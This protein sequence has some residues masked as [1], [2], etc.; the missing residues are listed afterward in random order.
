VKAKRPDDDS[1]GQLI[2][3]FAQGRDE[4]AFA[5]LV[6]RRGALVAGV[7]ARMLKSREDAEDAFQAVFLVL[8][9]R[10]GALRRF[11]SLGGWLHAVAVRVCLNER[12]M[13]R[14]RQQRLHQAA[15]GAREPSQP[16]RS[17]ELKLVIDEEL[18]ALP[19]RLREVVVLCDL[20]GYTRNEVARTLSLTLGA[21]SNRLTR[22]REMLRKRLVRHGL[23]VA[24]G[25]VA[26]ALAKCG[27]AAPAVTAEL[28][29]TTVRNTHIFLSGTAAAK[30]TL[31][32]RISSLAEGA[33]HAMIL[34]QWKSAASLFALV[35][36]SLCGIAVVSS[37]VPGM[38]SRAAAADIFFDDFEDGSLTNGQPITFTDGQP[39][40]W[41]GERTA[42]QIQNGSLV[43][44]GSSVPLAV[45][46]IGQLSDVS[47]QVQLRV[48]AGDGA[49]IGGRRNV[50]F[51]VTNYHAYVTTNE[52]GI[53]YGPNGTP[54]L[55]STQI[56]FDPRLEDVILQLDIIGNSITYWA[57]P[58]DEARPA[59][60]LGSVVDDTL[61]SGSIFF[62]GAG[63]T[64]GSTAFRYVHVANSPIPVPE[65]STVALAA[66]A[67][68]LFGF[69]WLRRR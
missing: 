25:G 16:Q 42:L 37:V 64:L 2:G 40:T 20:E 36:A 62:A 6:E 44:S 68:I 66:I 46:S 59:Q 43:I 63:N 57:W 24:V 48:L 41:Q 45:P 15:A 58:A 39:V 1:D 33:L 69:W 5:T 61:S 30:T 21:V 27:Q 17:D 51:P 65:P 35:V 3:R 19:S 52:V 56:D 14:R 49:V 60:P 4:Q 9:R 34:S 29:Q 32:L 50:G 8:A 31:G 10:A 47:I 38:I 12:K 53:A 55:H 18:A 22:G 67:P 54:T 7:C 26:T 11:S 13:K 23:P 28:V